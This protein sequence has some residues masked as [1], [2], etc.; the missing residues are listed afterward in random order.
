MSNPLTFTSKSSRFGLPFLFSGQAQK[1][2]YINE[3]H[4]LIDALLHPVVEGSADAPPPQPRDGE[5]WIV[6][7]N[8]T[9]DWLGHSQEIAC[10][11]SGSWLFA[12]PPEGMRVFER[13]TSVE[14]RYRNGW[15]SPV[16]ITSPSGGMNID[17][18]A[19]AAISALLQALAAYGM[20][21]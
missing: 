5:C 6:G 19:R 3:A 7:S 16:S 2:F 13:P 9:S 17:V 11:Q 12:T 1:E 18:E 10:F 20:I 15:Q 14:M 4:V 8:P 21:R